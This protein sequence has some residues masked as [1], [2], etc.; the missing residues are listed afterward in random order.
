M[1]AILPVL[2]F[3]ALLRRACR[4]TWIGGWREAV[5][6]AMAA[7]SLVCIVLTEA[8]SAMHALSFWPVAVGWTLATLAAFFLPFGKC[9]TQV[10]WPER[11]SSWL[12]WVLAGGIGLTLVLPL[13]TA[14]MASP[15]NMDALEYHMPR[16]LH[17]IW[18]GRVA[19]YPTP[20][21]RELLFPPLAEYEALHLY[22]LWGG[23][24]LVNLVQWTAFAGIAIAVSLVARELGAERRGQMLSALFFLTLPTAALQA[25]VLKNDILLALWLVTTLW[26]LLSY[27]ESPALG[28]GLAMGVTFGLAM[29][30]KLSAP[31]YMLL[32]VAW[33]AV[34]L[35]SR[36]G[37]VLLHGV[38]AGAI[39]LVIVSPVFVRNLE[40]FG[41][42]VGPTARFG[43]MNEHRS[44]AVVV[45]NVSRALV[46]HVR[47]AYTPAHFP[48]LVRGI[49]SL[50]E[51]LGLSPSAAETT[52]SEYLPRPFRWTRWYENESG[53]P[54]HLL[55]AAG[56]VA[57]LLFCRSC[58]PERRRGLAVLLSL[59]GTA[60][61]FAALFKHT[62]QVA[63]YH[64][65]MFAMAAGVMGWS[66]ERVRLK[67]AAGMA[68]L[69]LA[70]IVPVHVL[71][72]ARPWAGKSAMWRFPRHQRF[73]LE[74]PEARIDAWYVFARDLAE[75]DTRSVGIYSSTAFED[76]IIMREANRLSAHPVRFESLQ[77][78]NA[79]ETLRPARR[80][81]DAVVLAGGASSGSELWPGG[82]PVA[83]VSLYGQ[84]YRRVREYQWPVEK[85]RVLSIF[86]YRSLARNDSGG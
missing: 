46:A 78:E 75:S 85:G 62:D 66:L 58:L 42:P 21:L 82:E 84:S 74:F 41:D 37:T 29:M 30:T 1:F 45:S 14:L 69:L 38:L 83:V 77:V 12:E 73:L 63:R 28:T 64:L 32:P 5:L 86:L 50:H 76:Y 56:G 24:V 49:I 2:C 55:L 15:N 33:V 25:S 61:L 59:A 43:V 47:M 31:F 81:Y 54:L 52:V 11:P 17:W 60:V 19:H 51:W 16:V 57:W 48:L 26:L 34:R 70:L 27:V 4:M 35:R 71:N 53:D 9:D 18:Q 68:L 8:V 7:T 22:L 80:S 79:S 72:E 10:R 65:P 36:I 44:A 40:T 3:L 39:A 20:D 13:A 67:P 6:A 23:D